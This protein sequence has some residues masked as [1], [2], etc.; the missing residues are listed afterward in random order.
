M[1]TKWSSQ[2]WRNIACLK[3]NLLH[4]DSLIVSMGLQRRS[5]KIGKPI[6][7]YH[8]ELLKKK[9]ILNA[10]RTQ[11]IIQGL[12]LYLQLPQT[13][14][15]NTRDPVYPDRP[16]NF[17]IPAWMHYLSVGLAVGN[18]NGRDRIR[19]FYVLLSDQTG[20]GAHP[21]VQIGWSV[22]LTTQLHL[23][24]RLRMRGAVP[25]LS[26]YVFRACRGKLNTL[27]FAKCSNGL[28]ISKRYKISSVKIII[29]R[30]S[31]SEKY[32]MFRYCF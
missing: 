18:I 8:W 7:L 20:S 19:G 11:S 23:V 22:K 3:D 32:L 27:R 10:F 25:L 17:L 4:Y 9:P 13:R 15:P 2:I 30:P 26:L 28:W 5:G 12:T 16:S 1:G 31:P 21:A 29:K 24:P 14:T 6:T